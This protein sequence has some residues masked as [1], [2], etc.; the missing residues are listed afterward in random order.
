M[1]VSAGYLA[2]LQRA[3]RIK[4]ATADV[5]AELTDLIEE[6]RRDMES[7]GVLAIK[8]TDETDMLILGAV[9]CFVRW[10]KALTPEDAAADMA[11]YMLMRDELRRKAAYTEAVSE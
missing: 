8:T 7:L 1:A 3:V 6:A 4:T 10:K 5:T 9:R 2:K 11:A